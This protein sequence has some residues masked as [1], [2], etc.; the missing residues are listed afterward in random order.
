M[1]LNG[2]NGKQTAESLN[3]SASKVSRSLALLDLPA[4]VQQ[5]VIDGELAARAAYE[6]SKLSNAKVQSRVANDTTNGQLTHDQARAMVKQR[7]G[8]SS[9]KSRGFKQAFFAEDGIKV[10]VSAPR[11]VTYDDVAE[12]LRQ[13]VEEVQHYIDQGRTVL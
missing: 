7:K 8:K 5:R 12:A 6:V 11:K 4:D 10:S 1:E 2:W 9:A 3:I 13:A